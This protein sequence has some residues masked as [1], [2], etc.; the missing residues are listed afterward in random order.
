[1]TQRR[2]G[3]VYAS[4]ANLF[5]EL[6][7]VRGVPCVVR[8]IVRGHGGAALEL[9]RRLRADTIKPET[10]ADRVERTQFDALENLPSTNRPVVCELCHSDITRGMRGQ[11]LNRQTYSLRGAVSARRCDDAGSRVFSVIYRNL[12]NRS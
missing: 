8:P 3:A 1:M 11:V 6:G 5:R 12:S 7:R 2:L 10:E 9:E 4:K